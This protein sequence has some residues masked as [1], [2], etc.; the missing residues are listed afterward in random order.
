MSES[1]ILDLLNDGEIPGGCDDCNAYQK[2]VQLED[3]LF[4]LTVF[5]DDTCPFL[6]KSGGK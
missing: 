4:K 3:K 2:V 5:H 1:N 6:N